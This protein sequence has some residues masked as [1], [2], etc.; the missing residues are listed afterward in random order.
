MDELVH[1]FNL[2]TMKRIYITWQ[3]YNFVNKENAELLRKFLVY[4]LNNQKRR[5]LHRWRYGAKLAK[6]EIIKANYDK[7]GE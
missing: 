5:N 7:A 2:R 4:I 6:E 1:K 3:A